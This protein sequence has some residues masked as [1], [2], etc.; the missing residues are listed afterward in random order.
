MMNPVAG[1]VNLKHA[2]LNHDAPCFI[3]SP[4]VASYYLPALFEISSLFDSLIEL[5]QEGDCFFPHFIYFPCV[6]FCVRRWCA[7]TILI[8]IVLLTLVST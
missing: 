2:L 7:T 8:Y 4:N 3:P 5:Q 1:K 6:V